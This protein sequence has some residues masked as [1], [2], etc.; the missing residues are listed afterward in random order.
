MVRDLMRI[1]DSFQPDIIVRESCEYGAW[2]AASVLALPMAVV[3]VVRRLPVCQLVRDIGVEL[4]RVRRDFGLSMDAGLDTLY[5]DLCLD[6]VPPL[7]QGAVDALPIAYNVRLLAPDNVGDGPTSGWLANLDPRY[8]TVY[9]TMGTVYNRAPTI[10]NTIIAALGQEDVNLILA[11]G[12]NQ[13]PS[14]YART[15]PRVHIASYLPQTYILSRSD[16]AITHCGINTVLGALAAGVPICALPISADQ[17]GNARRCCDLGVAIAC[18]HINVEDG[19]E[20]LR[21]TVPAMLGS[22]ELRNAVQTLLADGSY[23]RC[24]LEVRDQIWSLPG[25]ERAAEL[26]EGL[27]GI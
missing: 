13:D 22:V 9:A 6:T 26:V 17:P 3:C 11:V 27:S 5:G 19:A 2:V 4:N 23:R 10:F 12:R 18:T 7:V 1:A 15:S 14:L 20:T 25:P 21:A 24:A 8:P 16:V